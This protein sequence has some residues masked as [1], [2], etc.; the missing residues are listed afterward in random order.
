MKKIKYPIFYLLIAL[1]FSFSL[2]CTSTLANSLYT[3][4][5]GIKKSIVEYIQKKEPKYN[6]AEIRIELIDSEAQ[7]KSLSKLKNKISFLVIEA[8]PNFDPLKA[9]IIPLKV[10]NNGKYEKKIFIKAK[11]RIFKPIVVAQKNI[12]QGKIILT[13]NLSLENKEIYSLNGQY[14]YS[15]SNI[16]GKQSKINIKS[17]RAIESWMLRNLPEVQKND[18]ILLIVT[19]KNVHVSVDG[20]AIQDGYLGDKIRIK[21]NGYAKLLTGKVIGLKKVEIQ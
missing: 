5:S 16:S 21:R 10:F 11:V 20:I 3:I 19:D 1:V 6:T 13:D 18:K 15:L 7:I 9:S 12:A 17:G 4:E 8:Y 2:F 14:F